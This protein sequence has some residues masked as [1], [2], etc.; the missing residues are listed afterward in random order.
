[1]NK[2]LLSKLSDKEKKDYEILSKIFSKNLNENQLT[3]SIQYIKQNWKNYSKAMIMALLLNPAIASAL[4]TNAPEVYKDMKVEVPMN[5][6]TSNT[7]TKYQKTFDFSNNFKSAE[8]VFTN[9]ESLQKII[10]DIQDFTQSKSKSR[11]TITIQASESQVTNPK[12]YKKGELAKERANNL[13]QVFKKLGFDNI[14]IKTEIGTTPYVA[15]KN[16]PQDQA[17]T[18]E[19]FVKVV[20]SLNAQDLCSFSQDG[21]NV[22][23]GQGNSTN[24][25]VTFDEIV[26]GK[27]SIEFTPESIPDRLVLLDQNGKIKQDTGYISTK[28]S[29]YP[30]WKYVPMY[31]AGLTQM[32]G[33]A[34]QGSKIKKIKAD[35]IDSLIKQLLNTSH[36]WKKDTRREIKEGINL[37]QKLLDSGVTEFIIYD[38]LPGSQ[39]IP[40]DSDNNDSQIKIYSPLG[41]TG[42][43]IKGVC[44]M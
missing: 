10:K 27:G 25:Y 3:Q 24:D 2:S 31:V 42:Y 8:T 43:N 15:G 35:N 14:D 20:I 12:G 30:Q 32:S 28:K 9:K 44:K 13:Q 18:N 22:S 29:Q 7:D 40:F 1:M 34:V 41:Q 37:L 23:L 36:D 19:Q 6:T 33:E 5:S 26:A 16:N 21:A 17:Y 38:T 39:N 4:E 11:Y